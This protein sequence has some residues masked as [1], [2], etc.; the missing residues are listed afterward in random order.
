M[1][2]EILK[3][4]TKLLKDLETTD[5]TVNFHLKQIIEKETKV[6]D[7]RI[8]ISKCLFCSKG[9]LMIQQNEFQCNICFISGN[10]LDFI[11]A[12]YQLSEEEAKN[13]LFNIFL[14]PNFTKFYKKN[15]Y[16]EQLD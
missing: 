16:G 1:E 3:S 2:Q 4:V 13:K 6:K 9:E 14:T 8:F 15:N 5:N 7:S 10:A 11:M 12:Y